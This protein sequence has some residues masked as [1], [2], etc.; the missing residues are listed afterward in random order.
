VSGGDAFLQGL[1]REGY[2][3]GKNI[4]IEH[5]YVEGPEKIDQA[6][7]ELVDLKVEAIFVV[8][9]PAALVVKRLT[10]S[11]PIVAANMADP[12]ADG[13]VASLSQPGGNLT[14]N[15]FLGPELNSKRVQILRELV[16]GVSLGCNIRVYTAHTQCKTW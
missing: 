12:V 9:T 10:S 7:R 11:I 1:L 3:E 2:I 13:L 16:P 5:R 4:N 14:G 6:A 8:G 15:T